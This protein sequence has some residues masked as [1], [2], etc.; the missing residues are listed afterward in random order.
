MSLT[1]S[2]GVRQQDGRGVISNIAYNIVGRDLAFDFIRDKWDE[3]T[4]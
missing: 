4:K 2:S 3:V 1:P